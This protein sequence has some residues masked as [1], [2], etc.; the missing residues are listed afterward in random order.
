ML[1]WGTG[2]ECKNLGTISHRDCETC[3]R[4][5]P[6]DLILEYRY[7]GMYWIFNFITG[8]KYWLL[9]DVCQR[10]WELHQTEV[11]KHF[12]SLPIPFM[13]RFGLAVLVGG[14]TSFFAFMEILRVLS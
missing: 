10:G 13:Q 14:V 9:C 1:V 4:S 5:R 2:G 3:E 8:K 6:Y 11:E 7:W 12:E